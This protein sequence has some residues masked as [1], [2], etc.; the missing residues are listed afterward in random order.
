MSVLEVCN[1]LLLARRASA[2]FPIPTPLGFPVA[3]PPEGETVESRIDGLFKGWS[4]G[5]LF[6]L[7]NGQLWQQQDFACLYRYAYA[8]R[9]RIYS[10]PDGYEMQV[11]GA[12][13]AVR[14]RRIR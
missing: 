3:G 2:E 14:V 10:M 1:L 4:G 5:T 7:R 11:E 12:Q 13:G 8:P 9:V 6:K